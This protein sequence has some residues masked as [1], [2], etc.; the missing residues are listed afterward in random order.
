MNHVTAGAFTV[1]MVAWV[2]G[3]PASAAEPSAAEIVQRNVAARGGLDAWRKVETMVWI[4]HIESAHAPVPS[5]QFKLEQKR[6]NRTRLQIN[7]LT[8]K[9]M[10][11]FDGVHGWKLRPARGRS[12][13]QPF[14]P[15]EVKFAQ[16]GPGLDGPL[17]DYAAKGHTVELA[18]VDDIEGRKAYHLTVH[19]AKGGTDEVWLDAQTYLDVRMDRM[20][21]EPSGA[22]RRVSTSF[23]DYRTVEGLQIPFLITTG[24][25]AG[26][27]SDRMQIER[28]VLNAPLDDAT[29]GNPAAPRPTR[30][31]RPKLA[32]QA[33]APTWP[34]TAP[35]AASETPAPETP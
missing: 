28:V 24:G 26:T 34:S 3:G 8:D 27:T 31:A 1:A 18:G 30:R 21:D 35:T 19:L 6:P 2:S 16:S 13:A 12:A 23:G 9:S 25:G 20:A 15:Q 17:V 11:I 32:P 4:G 29:F 7:A 10:R 33:R 14:T 22:P 5:L